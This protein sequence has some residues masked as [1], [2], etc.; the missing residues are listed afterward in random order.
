MVKTVEDMFSRF[1]TIPAYDGQTDRHLA[2]A[3]SA[4]YYAYACKNEGC[5]KRYEFWRPCNFWMSCIRSALALHR[6]LNLKKNQDHN[7][8]CRPSLSAT[9]F[10]GLRSTQ[11]LP[12]P[13][14]QQ[15][16]WRRLDSGCLIMFQGSY[17][18]TAYVWDAAFYY[19]CY[20]GRSILQST[21]SN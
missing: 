6:K 14:Q 11:P 3:Q 17:I 20:R 10:I 12:P 13:Q 19:H 4:L 16:Q 1:D 9:A 7:R 8:G 21:R 18:R 2:T 15:Y 5:R